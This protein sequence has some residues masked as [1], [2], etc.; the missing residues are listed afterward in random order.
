VDEHPELMAE[1]MLMVPDFSRL[2][3]PNRES[4]KGNGS[5][6]VVEI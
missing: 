6:G 5:D 1:Q 4:D 2:P 3:R